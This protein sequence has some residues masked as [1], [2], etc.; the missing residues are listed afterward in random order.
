MEVLR[1]EES[2]ME[3]A[4][5]AETWSTATGIVCSACGDEFSYGDEACLLRIVY[6]LTDGSFEDAVTATGDYALDPQFL[7]PI[8]WE[9]EKEQVLLCNEDESI[10]G[11]HFQ[12][13]ACRCEICNGDIL[14]GELML[15]VQL[16]NFG[17]SPRIPCGETEAEFLIV[18]DCPEF[19]C[20]Q[21][22]WMLN[23]QVTT[24]WEDN[25]AVI[26]E[27]ADKRASWE[28]T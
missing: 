21:C 26:E 13:A 15:L 24:Y 4:V 2:S 28:S 12:N 20:S 14:A 1:K 18:R 11:S 16:G 10:E 27:A 9:S 5:A 22:L 25:T 19:V 6:V 7:E 17:V 23:E 8:C 3:Q